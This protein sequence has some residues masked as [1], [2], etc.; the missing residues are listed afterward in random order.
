[1]S[2]EAIAQPNPQPTPISLEATEG[3]PI[4]VVGNGRSGTT[5][6][7]LML[8]AHPRIY[9][10]HETAFY[11]WF[12]GEISRGPFEVFLKHYSK[13]VNFRW[14]R[15]RPEDI[16]A[17]LPS[18]LPRIE[19][20]R[21]L[22]E[23]MRQKSAS[24]GRVRYGDKSPTHTWHL[25]RI[26]RDFPDA[27]VIAMVRDPRGE[28]A[29]LSRMPW[30]CYKDFPNCFNNELAR[31]AIQRQSDKLIVV[32]LEDLQADPRL[33]MERVLEFVGEPWNNAVLDHPNHD[34][35]PGRMPDVPWFKSSGTHVQRGD[36]PG[37]GMSP[38][39]VAIVEMLCRKSMRLRGYPPAN[40]SSSP[41]KLATLLRIASSMPEVV[42]YGWAGGRIAAYYQNPE[43]WDWYDE[44][45]RELMK[46]LNPS[47]WE[48][49]PDFVFPEAPVLPEAS[50]EPAESR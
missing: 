39:R 37:S 29:S 27:R 46:K 2:D 8:S 16:L 48:K 17:R 22:E 15:L 24:L 12:R 41:G 9:I 25:P 36:E 20:W 11:T 50:P 35:D 5:L 40:L 14:L 21:A 34:P 18:P 7:E 30:G 28:A 47:Y 44:I 43:H 49:R 42:R 31:R 26:Y 13:T 45:G 19:A 38:E 33:Q 6:M 32:R 1:M 3:P 10:C 23:I 4:F